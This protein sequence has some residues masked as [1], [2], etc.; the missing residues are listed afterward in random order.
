MSAN[1]FFYKTINLFVLYLE[2][3]FVVSILLVK[4]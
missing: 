1:N 4:L 3:L 2:V